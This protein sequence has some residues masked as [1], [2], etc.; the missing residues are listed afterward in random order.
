[1]KSEVGRTILTR[2]RILAGD[3][4]VDMYVHLTLPTKITRGKGSA[5]DIN[6]A[7]RATST[8]ARANCCSV[9]FTVR[10]YLA[11]SKGDRFYMTRTGGTATAMSNEERRVKD[12]VV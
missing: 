10:D 8:E 4:Y 12:I 1:M 9:W 7:T 2:G 11:Y 6:T 5:G 3:L